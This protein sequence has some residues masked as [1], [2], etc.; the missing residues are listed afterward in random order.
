[1]PTELCH[2]TAR[3]LV[4]AHL[5]RIEHRRRAATAWLR[6]RTSRPWDVPHNRNSSVRQPPCAATD[7]GCHSFHVVSRDS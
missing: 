1:M 3:E 4:A 5:E 2:L 6:S 7:T